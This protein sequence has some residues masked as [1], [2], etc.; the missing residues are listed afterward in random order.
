MASWG[1]P[2]RPWEQQE[3]HV[4]IQVRIFLDFGMMFGPHFGSFSGTMGQKSGVVLG[5]VSMSVLTPIPGSNSGHLGVF[6]QGFRM[7]SIAKNNFSQ[8]SGFS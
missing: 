5:F 2:A 7:E 1:H 6:K 8:K 4:G 3:E